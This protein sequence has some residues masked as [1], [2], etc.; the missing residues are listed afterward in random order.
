MQNPLG[1]A[2]GSILYI[3]PEEWDKLWKRKKFGD[4]DAISPRQNIPCNKVFPIQYKLDTHVAP[5]AL[6]NA[7]S[8]TQQLSKPSMAELEVHL[9]PTTVKIKRSRRNMRKTHPW[10]RR[11]TKQFSGR[12][13]AFGPQIYHCP[14]TSALELVGL[15]VVTRTLRHN[16]PSGRK[17]A[18]TEKKANK[19]S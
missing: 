17:D 16:S 7:H 18:R 14:G 2:K 10:R 19:F 9:A 11:R 15:A 6:P 12:M 1:I 5:T 13:R 8:T 3:I 4:K